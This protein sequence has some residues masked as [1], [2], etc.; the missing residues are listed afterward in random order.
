MPFSRNMLHFVQHLI[1]YVPVELSQSAR[2]Q[3]ALNTFFLMN[4]LLVEAQRVVG[5]LG[6]HFRDAPHYRVISEAVNSPTFREVVDR[7][8]PARH[9]SGFHFFPEG[10]EAVANRGYFA[11]PPEFVPFLSAQ[12]PLDS[13]VHFDLADRIPM[14]LILGDMDRTNFEETFGKWLK[15]ASNV[16][17]DFISNLNIFLSL[18]AKAFGA[19]R[20]Q[21][22]Q[23]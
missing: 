5:G 7:S 19:K 12:G 6:S 23:E 17:A 3:H 18:N 16:T 10:A 21:A 2:N 4:S 8:R 15:D 14:E 9:W 11:D 13:S 22:P 20:R 1:V